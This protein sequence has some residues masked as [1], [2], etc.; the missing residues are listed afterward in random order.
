MLFLTEGDVRQLLPMGEA[1]RLMRDAFGRL[2]KKEALNQPRQRL[3]LPTGS[4]LH[5]MAGGDGEFFGAKVYSTH[6]KH[7]ARFVFLLYRAEDAALLAVLQ[8]DALGQIRTGA[9]SGLATDLLARPEAD[10]VGMIGTGYQARTQL[11]AVASVR[12]LNYGRVWG[13]TPEKRAAF[14]REYTDKLGIPVE[15]AASAQDAVRDAGVVITA[16]NSREPVLEAGWIAPGT[17]VNAMGSNHA[18]R[19]ELPAEFVR[20]AEK[21]V[22]DSLEQ[23]R[24]EAGDLVLALEAGEWNRVVELK[25]V[26][27]GRAVGRARPNDV[28]VFKSIG[29]AVEDVAAAGYVY[30]RAVETGAG[31]S[32][33]AAHS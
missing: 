31:R 19:R 13:P 21:L 23:A 29:L 28:T 24:L 33:G 8:A 12:R 32:L 25:D 9:A 22:V 10:T 11:E 6:P 4:V 2:A 26:L 30:R 7:G 14:A 3:V 18:E 15:A 27:A 5:Y 16:T 20:K 17:H 1:L